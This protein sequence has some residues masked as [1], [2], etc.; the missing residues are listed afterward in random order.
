MPMVVSRHPP[1]SPRRVA[2]IGFDFG[3]VCVPIAN[4][5]SGSTQVMLLLARRELERMREPVA[6]GVRLVPF[7]KPRLRQPL[8]QAS[9]CR[10]LLGRLRSFA[11]DVVHLQQGHLWFNFALPLLPDAP[12]VVTIHDHT[13]HPGDR[14]S[15]KTPVAITNLA[16]RRAD[17]LIVHA[18]RLKQEVVALRNLD[19]ARIHVVPHV[20]IDTVPGLPETAD[21]GHT[22]L[23]FGRLWPYKGLDRLIAA[24]PLISARVP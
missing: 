4:A 3:E 18:E 16:F 20:A 22:V 23:F 8:R 1:R 6:A 24:E 2:L 11:P 15:R 9:M 14:G 12:L 7:D 5:L 19:P 17:Q 21:D 10:F 13:P